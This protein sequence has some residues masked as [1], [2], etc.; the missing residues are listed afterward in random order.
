MGG[1]GWGGDRILLYVL[2]VVVPVYVARYPKTKH[3]LRLALSSYCMLHTVMPVTATPD[4]Q[5][6]ARF[7][8]KNR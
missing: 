7:V 8:M 3:Q 6:K 4:G 2:L 1:G 5:R